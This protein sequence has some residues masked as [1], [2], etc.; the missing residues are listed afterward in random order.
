MNKNSYVIRATLYQLIKLLS[1]FN[2]ITKKLLQNIYLLSLYLL[3]DVRF[4]L[5]VIK[6]KLRVAFSC[7]RGYTS[8]VKILQKYRE[9]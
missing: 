6:L 7:C 2:S 8:Y 1:A 9:T 4:H 5:T 3:Y